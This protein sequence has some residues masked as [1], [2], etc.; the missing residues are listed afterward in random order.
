MRSFYNK[1]EEIT[2]KDKRYKADAYEFVLRALWF[3]QKKLKKQGHISGKELLYG[4]RDF[5]LD[6]YGPMAKTVLKHWGIKAT[7]DI[8]EIVFNMVENGL[9]SKTDEDRRDDFKNVYNFSE[10]LD[11]FKSKFW[12]K[13][14]SATKRTAVN[15]K[16][17]IPATKPS[18]YNNFGTKNLN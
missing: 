8:G 5:V 10:E 9:L 16:S 15:Q 17:K 14:C 18:S 13:L 3:T 7:E 12:N 11:I 1:V 4:V 2:N 6:Q